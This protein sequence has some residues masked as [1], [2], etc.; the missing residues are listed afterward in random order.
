MSLWHWFVVSIQSVNN[1][2]LKFISA[3]LKHCFALPIGLKTICKHYGYCEVAF[4]DKHKT[5][6]SF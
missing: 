1:S 2:K 5:V 3:Y 6:E 4:D